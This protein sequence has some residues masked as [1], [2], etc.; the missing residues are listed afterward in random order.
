M[1]DLSQQMYDAFY[2]SSSAPSTNSSIHS[3]RSENVFFANIMPDVNMDRFEEPEP[4]TPTTLQ[5]S[6]HSLRLLTSDV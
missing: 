4:M 2:G 5:V 1:D 3:N 6:V